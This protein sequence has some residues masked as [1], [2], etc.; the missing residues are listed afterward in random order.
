MPSVVDTAD[1]VRS[2]G[3]KYSCIGAQVTLETSVSH[4]VVEVVGW[5]VNDAIGLVTKT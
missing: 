5:V 1:M 4:A 2:L 3:D